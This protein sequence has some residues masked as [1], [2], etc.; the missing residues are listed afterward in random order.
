LKAYFR[1]LLLQKMI[2]GPHPKANPLKESLY[3]SI[4]DVDK[5]SIPAFIARGIATLKRDADEIRK[6]MA[7]EE[8]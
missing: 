6:E 7:E 2:A 3:Q 5:S 1:P 8:N 4:R